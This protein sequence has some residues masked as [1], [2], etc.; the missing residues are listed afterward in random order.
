MRGHL[1]APVKLQP[2]KVLLADQDAQLV[3]LRLRKQVPVAVE[4]LDRLQQHLRVL[5]GEQGVESV[6]KEPEV[7][8]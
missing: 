2:H 5:G 8:R 1:R 6:E 7:K 4:E 3:R